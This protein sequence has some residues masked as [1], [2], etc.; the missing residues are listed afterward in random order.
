MGVIEK[1]MTEVHYSVKTG[2]P[3]K[4]QALDVIKL[5]QANKTLPLERARMRIRLTL[6]AKEGKR[7]KDKILEE[8]ENVEEEDW[9][10][11]WELIGTIDPGSLRILNELLE[12]ETKGKGKLETLSTFVATE[13]DAGA[14]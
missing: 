4:S 8:I 3:A 11:E 5:L 2:K 1:A 13:G 7:L 10:E 12:V 14:E 6:P 9:D